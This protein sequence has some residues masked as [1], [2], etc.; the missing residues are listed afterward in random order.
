[1]VLTS[2]FYNPFFRHGGPGEIEPGPQKILVCP[3]LPL[4]KRLGSVQGIS[5]LLQ[6]LLFPRN[7]N[8]TSIHMSLDASPAYPLA[9]P[10]F[11]FL[12][13]THWVSARKALQL[14]IA[15]AL[16]PPAGVRVQS[17]GGVKGQTPETFQNSPNLSMISKGIFKIS[18][19]I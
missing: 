6:S 11:W 15:G 1:M 17:P 9:A 16:Q 18:V 14:G 8:G 4:N 19:K 13:G 2:L 10:L 5:G 12:W 3:I 7:H